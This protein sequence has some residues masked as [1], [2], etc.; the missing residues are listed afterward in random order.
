MDETEKGQRSS[1]QVR[2]LLASIGSKASGIA[3]QCPPKPDLLVVIS[4]RRIAIE[5]TD[6][7][8]DE[9]IMGGSNLRKQ[10][11][12]D[13]REGKIK[14]Y[15]V[16]PD[17]LPGITKRIG[18][19]TKKAYDTSGA[20]ETWLAI[21]AGVSQ[22]GALASTFIFKLAVN[23][24]KLNEHTGDMLKTSLFSRCYLHCAITE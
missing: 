19:K 20:D 21:F 10:E 9:Q 13:A 17:P 18:E 16:P 2:R 7:H 14:G 6:Y 24:S 4:D 23:C 1:E 8:S 12:K 5:T 11:E 22:L 15:W 3:P